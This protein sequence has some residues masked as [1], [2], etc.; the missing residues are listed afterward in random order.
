MALQQVIFLAFTIALVSG[1]DAILFESLTAAEL[2][3]LILGQ[4]PDLRALAAMT[5]SRIH[6]E[7]TGPMQG[8]IVEED[9]NANLDCYPWL[10]NFPGGSVQ[11]LFQQRDENGVFSK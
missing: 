5:G 7:I 8:V 11:W 6:I 4:N 2:R 1:Q 3:S 10:S 9:V